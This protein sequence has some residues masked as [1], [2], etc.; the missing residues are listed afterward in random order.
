M[1]RGG[2]LE[3]IRMYVDRGVQGRG[4]GTT[5]VGR[6]IDHARAC[7]VG[8]VV[9]TTPSVNGDGLRFYKDRMGFVEEERF[10]IETPRRSGGVGTLE[11]TQ[12]GLGVG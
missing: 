3:L 2:E 5:L 9:V 8:R 7:R 10:E 12:L 4:V 1:R 6:L 11:I